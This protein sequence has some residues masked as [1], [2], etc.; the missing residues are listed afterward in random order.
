MKTLKITLVIAGIALTPLIGNAQEK[1]NEKDKGQHHEK[2]VTALQLNEKQAEQLKEIHQKTQKENKAIKAKMEPLKVEMKKLK[3]EKKAL[4]D[5]KIKE[6]E[7]ILTPEQF[8]KF[9]E[10]KA[11]RKAKQKIKK[12]KK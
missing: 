8:A 1:H 5:A 7:A 12:G 3:E 2:M 6:I 11:A 9:K 10:L 4:H